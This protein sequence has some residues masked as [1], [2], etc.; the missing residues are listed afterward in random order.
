M[1]AV[2]AWSQP[3]FRAWGWVEAAVCS[4]GGLQAVPALPRL[5]VSGDAVKSGP[6]GLRCL[7]PI[8]VSG[9]WTWGAEAVPDHALKGS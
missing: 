3:L 7:A 9:I 8:Q 1:L 5:C 6:D 4:P 2:L